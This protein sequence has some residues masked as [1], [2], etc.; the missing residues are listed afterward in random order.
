MKVTSLVLGGMVVIAG[1]LAGGEASAVTTSRDY[2]SHGT[3]GCQSALPVFDGNIRKRPLALG[4][5]GSN[6]AFVTCDSD[7]INNFG[8]G[9]TQVGIF[10]TNRAGAANVVVNCTLVD[11]AFT[12]FGSFPKS[13]APIAVGATG[14]II[15][16]TADN[17]DANFIAPA[18]SCALPAG[19]DISL[20][21]LVYPEEIG[22]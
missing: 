9:H 15:W 21:Q 18:L 8:S 20:V 12:A 13:S 22:T 5:E 17:E 2:L 10:F 7:S 14:N 1:T 3:A 16:T 4:N 19:V 6:T 11:G